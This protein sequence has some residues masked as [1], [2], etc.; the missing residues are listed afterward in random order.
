MAGKKPADDVQIEPGA[1]MRK[2]RVE[3]KADVSEPFW[4]KSLAQ[5][6]SKKAH[7]FFAPIMGYRASRCGIFVDDKLLVAADN[8]TPKCLVCEKLNVGQG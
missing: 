7:R 2:Q 3:R 4:A 6:F 8:H 1:K 5:P